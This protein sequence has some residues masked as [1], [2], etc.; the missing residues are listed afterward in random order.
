MPT[1]CC[2]IRHDDAI[3]KDTVV[4]YMGIGHDVV[5][6]ADNRFP[7][8]FGGRPIDCGIFPDDIV[9][10]NG[11]SGVLTPISDVLRRGADGDELG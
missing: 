1:Q 6:I 2:Q 3:S 7:C 4:G 11:E 5:L 10:S 9:I 8:L